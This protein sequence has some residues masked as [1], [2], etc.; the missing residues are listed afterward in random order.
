MGDVRRAGALDVTRARAAALAV[1]LAACASPAPAPAPLPTDVPPPAPAAPPDLFEQ[2]AGVW[3]W[4]DEEA[5]CEHNP[6]TIAFSPDRGEMT[7]RH[8][9]PIE[10]HDGSIRAE[11]RYRVVGREGDTLRLVDEDA[12]PAAGEPA[13]WQLRLISP[14]HYCWRRADWPPD[15]CTDPIE[16]C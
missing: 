10:M 13:E 4:L 16:R 2:L 6:H 1:A 14:N 8:V 3:G 7:L 12:D 11:A 15:T 5:S 9:A